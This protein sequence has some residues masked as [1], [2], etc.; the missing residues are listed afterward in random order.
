MYSQV[1]SR[2]HVSGSGSAE[3]SQAVQVGEANAA[4]MDLVVYAITGSS[5][6]LT[7]QLQESNDL[8]NWKDKGSASTATAIGYTLGSLTTSISSSY[9]RMKISITG[10]TP[11]SVVAAGISVSRQ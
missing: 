9:V 6:T 7:I 11:S 10:T 1:F 2:L 5:A 3:Y 4:Q 8:E